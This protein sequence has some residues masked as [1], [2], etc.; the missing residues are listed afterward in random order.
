M[1]E[2]EVGT[3]QPNVNVVNTG[4]WDFDAIAREMNERGVFQD[5]AGC[6]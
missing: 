2:W 4:A 6:K 3:N 1:L 5:S